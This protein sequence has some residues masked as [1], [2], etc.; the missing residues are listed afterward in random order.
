MAIALPAN[1]GMEELH[2]QLANAINE[3]I[4]NNFDRL[5][6]L[7]Y[8]IDINE[9]TLKKN[10]AQHPQE[11]A[12]KIIATMIIERQEQKIKSREQ[13]KQSNKPDDLEERW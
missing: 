2:L 10:L 7:L 6:M 13:F 11:D 3:L 4:K 9:T 12:G 8:R 1:I 5:V